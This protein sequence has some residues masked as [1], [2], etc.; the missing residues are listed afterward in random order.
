MSL[1][2]KNQKIV[3]KMITHLESKGFIQD[4]YGNMKDKTGIYRYKFQTT[5]YRLEKKIDTKP[6]QWMKLSG[7]YYKNVN[8]E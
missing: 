8:I 5:S 3:N 7:E 2:T 1:N 4:R 6:T